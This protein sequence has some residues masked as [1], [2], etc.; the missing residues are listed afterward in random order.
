[1]PFNASTFRAS[2]GSSRPLSAN[3]FDV[4]IPQLPNVLLRNMT[5]TQLQFWD[6][7]QFRITSGDLPARQFE[8]VDRRL[9]GPARMMP[10]GL[11][12]QTL[13]VEVLEDDWNRVREIFDLWQDAI[14]NEQNSYRVAYYDDMIATDMILT[15]YDKEGDPSRIYRFKEVFPLAINPSQMNWNSENQSVVIPIEFA[16]REW[17]GEDV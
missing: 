13:T 2:W 3:S 1:M 6:S 5:S 7:L 4:K 9:T 17:K 10:M 12:Y 15:T 8:I 14:Y 11:I 16:Y